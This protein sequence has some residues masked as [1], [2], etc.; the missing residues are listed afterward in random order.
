M[1]LSANTNIQEDAHLPHPH[2][3]HPHHYRPHGS[4]TQRSVC[5]QQRRVTTSAPASTSLA[6]ALPA[7]GD[8]QILR[9]SFVQNVEAVGQLQAPSGKQQT[10]KPK[11]TKTNRVKNSQNKIQIQTRKIAKQIN[12]INPKQPRMSSLITSYLF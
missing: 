4:H 1:W 6:A 3:Q 11:E 7:S 10:A 12:P 5:V 2:Y 9:F 8:S